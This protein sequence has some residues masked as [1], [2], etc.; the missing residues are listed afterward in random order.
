MRDERLDAL[1][2]MDEAN[3][4]YFTGFR[5]LFWQSP[6]RPWFLVVPLAGEPLAVIPEIGASLM[7]KTWVNDIRTWSSPDYE[8]DGISLLASVLEGQARIGL[9]MGRETG[10]R[11]PLR[12][13]FDLRDKLAG[14]EFADATDLVYRGRHIKSAAEV[15]YI[16]RICSI[17]SKSFD[18]AAS[19]FREG[20][21]LADTFRAFKT[22]L[23]SRG[24]EEVPYLVGGAGP[25]GYEDVISPAGDRKL[26]AGDVLMLDTGATLNGYFCDF[27][28]NFAI[29]RTSDAAKWAYDTLYRA[30]EEGLDTARP[31]TSCSDLFAAMARVIGGDGGNVGR[32]GHGLGIQLTETPSISPQDKTLLC[33]GMVNHP[34]AIYRTSRWPHDGAGREHTRLRWSAKTAHSPCITGTAR[35][36]I[37]AALFSEEWES[38]SLR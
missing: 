14:A 19:L 29:S 23:L 34:G 1:L 38:R 21:T 33:E 25:D 15:A 16:E 2:L 35:N 27:D 9:M 17:A 24:A 20:Q 8:D 3:V 22:I 36:L 18:Q 32:L 13:F 5:T 26:A 30:T 10:L 28:R 4:R 31:G 6:T 11:M 12:D 37:H 7:A